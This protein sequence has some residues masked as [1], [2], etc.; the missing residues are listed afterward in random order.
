MATIVEKT[1]GTGGDYATPALWIAACPANLVT[2]DQIWRGL[3]KNQEFSGTASISISGKTTNASCYIELTTEAGASFVD[4]ASKATNA[5]RY[6]PANGAAIK[7]T[8]INTAL[9]VDQAYTRISKIQVLNSD[10]TASAQPAFSTTAGADYL[11]LDRCI[12]ES[13]AMSSA[14]PGTLRATKTNAILTNLVVVQR[15]NSA[16]AIIALLAN[17]PIVSNCTFVAVGGTPLTTGITTL[18]IS[19]VMRNTYVGGVVAPEDGVVPAAK[20]NCFSNATATG[21]SVAPLSTST[22]ENVTDGTLDLRLKAESSLINAGVA[23]AT[24]APTDIIGTA[25]PAG[26]AYDVGAWEAAN[27]PDATA[28]GATLAATSELFGGAASGGAAGNAPGVTLAATSTLA[29]G[30]ATATNVGTFATLPMKNNTGTLLANET[31]ITLNIYNQ[32]TGALVVQKTGVT[33]NASGIAVV[34]DALILPGTTYA[35]EPVLT[36]GRRRLPTKA[37]T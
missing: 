2:A 15:K 18:Y 5:L 9:V 29:G 19:A 33:T 34:T 21:Y 26:A 32:T 20:T 14:V 10:T 24:Y 3:L 30:I 37:A 27:S 11:R 31:S 22:F 1:I 36:G 12:L 23:D 35:Y 6:N 13:S 25:R 28:T 17:G 4:H 8:S 7:C 16:S